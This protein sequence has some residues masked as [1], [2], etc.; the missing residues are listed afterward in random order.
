MSEGRDLGGLGKKGEGIKQ[1]RKNLIDT[2]NSVVIMREKG[3][4]A[5]MRR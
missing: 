1:K 5:D 4:G 3:R 2:G